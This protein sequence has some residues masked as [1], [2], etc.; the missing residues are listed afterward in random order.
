M[1][2]LVLGIFQFFLNFGDLPE[3]LSKTHTKRPLCLDSW[4]MR[5]WLKMRPAHHAM[6]HRFRLCVAMR[7]SL[8]VE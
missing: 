5:C 3:V 2:M 7:T 1:Q 6:G 8:T 4:Q